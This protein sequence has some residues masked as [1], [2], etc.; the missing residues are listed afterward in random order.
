MGEGMI[1]LVHEGVSGVD[2]QPPRGRGASCAAR[3]THP[4]GGGSEIGSEWLRVCTACDLRKWSLEA[5]LGPHVR[6]SE[7]GG[8]QTGRIGA[9]QSPVRGGRVPLYSLT[10]SE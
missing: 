6:A 3:V 8:V 1:V 5:P 4:R 7:A 10:S 9:G 2:G